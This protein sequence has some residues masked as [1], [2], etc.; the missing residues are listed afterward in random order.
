[1]Q[2]EE[3]RTHIHVSTG[4]RGFQTRADLATVAILHTRVAG[5]KTILLQRV[6]GLEE[7]SPL[8]QLAHRAQRLH[9]A[10][11]LAQLQVLAQQRARLLLLQEEGGS[12]SAGAGAHRLHS[13]LTRLSLAQ[14]GSPLAQLARRARRIRIAF[15]YRRQLR[16]RRLNSAQVLSQQRRLNSAQVLAQQQQ[17]LHTRVAAGKTILLQ[18]VFPLL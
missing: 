9:S 10:Q 3:D 17:I 7:G 12:L 14:Q 5:G 1:L 8:A 16:W 11:V 18:R 15:N 13:P 6:A 4:G 2:E